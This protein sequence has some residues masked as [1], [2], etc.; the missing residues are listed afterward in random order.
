MTVQDEALRRL[1]EAED[2][3]REALDRR[4]RVGEQAPAEEG[5]FGGSGWVYS[6]AE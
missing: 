2:D 1:Q 3:R 4:D 5:L 6:A